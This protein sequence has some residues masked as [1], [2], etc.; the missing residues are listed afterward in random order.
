MIKGGLVNFLDHTLENPMRITMKDINLR[1][2]NV[3]FSAKDRGRT[4]FQF[5]AHMVE[6]EVQSS[7]GNIAVEGWANFIKKD[8]KGGI[9]ITDLDAGLFSPYYDNSAEKKFRKFIADLSADLESHS[10]DMTV[11]GKLEIK[12]LSFQSKTGEEKKSASIESL[13]FQGLQSVAK[14]IAVEFRF[15]TKMDTF[16]MESISFSGN[17]FSGAQE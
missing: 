5:S 11:K 14:Q 2:S 1:A 4:K 15:K 7:A 13:I 10:N 8:M 6:P 3:N 12:D 16:K 17:I 9:K